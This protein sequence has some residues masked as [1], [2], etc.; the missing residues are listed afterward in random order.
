MRGLIGTYTTSRSKGIYQTDETLSSVSLFYECLDPKYLAIHNGL[1]A[2]VASV[3]GQGGL[4]LVDDEGQLVDQLAY[5]SKVSCY[6]AS[7]NGTLLTTN[8][9]TG[10]VSQLA[11]DGKLSLVKQVQ[12]GLGAHQ[13]VQ[14]GQHYWVPCLKEDTIRVLD[15]DL[16]EVD[17]IHFPEK[18]GPRH[19]VVVGDVAYV[20]TE[21]SNELYCID[22]HS[23]KILSHLDLLIGRKQ[24]EGTAAIAYDSGKIYVSTRYQDVISVIEVN[25]DQMRLVQV[26]SSMGVHPRDFALVPGGLV[27]VHKDD[28]RM[29]YIERHADG[30][31]G[32]VKRSACAPEAVSLIWKE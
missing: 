5:E 6:V 14:V 3:E 20:C 24:V 15:L 19:L 26:V 7:M 21:L 8:Y 16:N 17:Q 32:L 28:D 29:V 12:L 18:A 1:V 2:A 23:R 22:I 31:L 13:I 27:V 25:G 10:Q 11:F 4:I 30:S 9:H